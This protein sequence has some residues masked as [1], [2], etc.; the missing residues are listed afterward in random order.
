[1][2]MY[3]AMIYRRLI[4]R[5]E[6]YRERRFALP[7]PEFYEFNTSEKLPPVSTMRLSEAFSTGIPFEPPLELIVTRYNISYNVLKENKAL[8]DFLP[9]RGYSFFVHNVEDRKNTGESPADAIRN[10][11]DYCIE[12]DILRKFLLDH[13]EEVFDMYSLRWNE[14]DYKRAMQ[15][16]AYDE[17]MEKGMEKGLEKGK[18]D[19]TIFV[20]K[21]MLNM[22]RPYAE[23]TQATSMPPEEIA[24]IAEEAHLSY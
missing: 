20:V 14:E 24:R 5:H 21:N 17:G 3:A 2:L 19:T 11:T 22:K 6:L 12:H 13:Y 18:L 1:M 23:I 9:L 15:E 7:F 10:A 4:P 8:W 16:D